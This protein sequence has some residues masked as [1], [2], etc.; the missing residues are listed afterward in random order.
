[1][2]RVSMVSRFRSPCRERSGV[3]KRAYAALSTG[4]AA[5]MPLTKTFFSPAFGMLTD[6]F[7]ICWMVMDMPPCQSLLLLTAR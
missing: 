2:K 5:D 6:R 3:L 7:G 1:M 4:G